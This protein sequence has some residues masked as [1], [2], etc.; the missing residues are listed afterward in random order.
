MENKFINGDCMHP[1]YGLPSYPDNFFDLAVVD[2]PY[3]WG[4]A[5]FGLTATPKARKNKR[6]KKH[7][8]KDWNEQPTKVYWEQLFRVS[9]N[10][11]VWGGNYFTNVLPI[12]RGWIFWDKG[13]ENTNNFSAGEL[14]WTSFDKILKKV[15]T[16]N[17]IMPHQLQDN[18]HPCQKPIKLYQ[19]LLEN[20]AQSND[21]ILDTH[22]GSAS[23]LIAC[24]SMGFNYVGFELDSD[25]YE[26]AK[27][28]LRTVQ[29][30]LF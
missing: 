24:E 13:Y 23:S 4:D 1:E 10:Q 20:Y 18:V 22:V 30:R 6:I 5:F 16:T 25:Y 8:T 21:L 3:G 14:A 29:A 15:Y 11:I 26:A 12:S 2:P 28:R 17:R 9:K 19:W 7:E 27:K